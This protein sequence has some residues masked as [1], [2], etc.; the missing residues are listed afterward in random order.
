VAC[1]RGATFATISKSTIFFKKNEKKTET[2]TQVD[3]EWVQSQS[4]RA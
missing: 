1:A 3:C 4:R 2:T